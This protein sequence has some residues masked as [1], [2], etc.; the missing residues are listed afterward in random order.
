MTIISYLKSPAEDIDDDNRKPFQVPVSVSLART[1][2]GK[3]LVE[4]ASTSKRECT[5]I[6][7]I[8]V[9]YNGAA[10]L[11]ST[12]ESVLEQRRNDIEH[13]V[14]DGGS[15]DG[16]CDVL[17]EFDSRLDYWVSEPDG[18][19]YD[20][21][22]K[23]LALCK[24]DYVHF[25]NAG[26]RYCSP[27]ALQHVSLLLALQP[28]LLMNRVNGLRLD[29]GITL[30]PK[31]LGLNTYRHLFN[32]AYCHQGAF[33]RTSLLQT[34]G[35]DRTYK[36][37]A[38]FHALMLIREMTSSVL[39]TSEV[40]VDF[41]LDGVSSDWRKASALYAE[42]ERLLRALGEPRSYWSHWFGLLRVYFY[43][44]KMAIRFA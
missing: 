32:S 40:V 33:V 36:H 3:R 10:Q 11:R 18:G 31:T 5:L 15:T 29:G 37:F 39:E 2:G 8:T 14:I 17:H 28:G 43:R 1:Y 19:I 24:G 34:I 42:K 25:L 16:T 35:F 20:A 12:I 4:V 13:I 41:P 6:S 9:V 23:A 26:D 21:M 30:L 27:N 38:D 7:V 44:L 22:N